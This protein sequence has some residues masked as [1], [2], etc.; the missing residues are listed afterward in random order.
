MRDV[1]GEASFCQKCLQMEEMD[2]FQG[3]WVEKTT[4]KLS[5]K[6]MLGMQ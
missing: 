1:Y 2:L 5:G 3:V 6:K 4:H